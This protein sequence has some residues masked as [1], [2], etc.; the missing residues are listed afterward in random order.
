MLTE[1]RSFT[2][3]KF[4][5]LTR[6]FKDLEETTKP[7]EDVMPVGGGFDTIAF[8]RDGK[9]IF[10]GYNSNNKANYSGAEIDLPYL[11]NDLNELIESTKKD[12]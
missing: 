1:K 8:Y 5:K 9:E 4:D 3:E 7:K 11:V 2:R 6:S 12:K 10:K